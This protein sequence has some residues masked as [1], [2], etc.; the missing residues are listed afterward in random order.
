MQSR[1]EKFL[2]TVAKENDFEA[3]L[4]TSGQNRFYLFGMH[5]S[6]GTA[7]IVKDTAYFI[8]DFRYIELAQKTVK[9]AQVI[10]QDKL[11]RQINEILHRHNVKNIWVEES[12]TVGE[13]N[14][15]K[16]NIDANIATNNPLTSIINK[17]RSIKDAGERALIKTAQEITEAGFDYI[18]TQLAPGK[19][20]K[21]MAL[22]LETYMK[23]QGAQGLSF[24]T[25][26]VSGKNSSLPHGVPG[27]KLIEKGDFVTMDYAAA[28][29]G[30]CTDMTRTV[31]I[32]SV[33]DEMKHV[34]DIVLKS[35]IMA[36]EAIK[37]GAVCSDIDKIARDF[38][39]SNGYEGRFGHGLGHSYGIDI[40]ENPRF[41]SS[42]DTLLEEG[43]MIT[44]E[45]GIYL[46]EKFG[47]RIEDTVYVT[48]N[49]CINLTHSPKELII[50]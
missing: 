32:G 12:L 11:Y 8:I 18:C 34:Y 3:A 44:V 24:D 7:L 39:Y 40:H 22:E 31:A 28:Y 5:S 43:M 48:E 50:L 14:V 26:L 49:G 45:P 30:Y 25:I 41:S 42:D 47:V 33:T 35:Q 15:L 38:I 37:R 2:N 23:K 6:A 19:S 1:I 9:D 16:N 36:I 29:G 46:P 13:L 4:I 17:Q 21:D 10:L 27:D 20:E